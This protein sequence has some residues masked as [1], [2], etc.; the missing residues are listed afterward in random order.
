M[1]IDY[2]ETTNDLLTRIDIHNK[3]GGRDIDQW[4]LQ[5]LDLKPG[6]KILDVAC[7]GGKQCVSFH[8]YLKG[9]CEITGGDVNS[10]LLSQ[11]QLENGKL[12][13]PF[14]IMPLDFDKPLPFEDNTFDLVS[15]C[16][17]IYYASDIPFT[18]REMHRVLKPGGRLFTTGPMPEN[19]KVFYDIIR[20]ATSKTIPP[21]P[22]SSRY[23]SEIFAA[24]QNS[25]KQA[26]IHI[27]ENPLTFK[28]S[29]PFLAYTRASL[30][31]DRKLW[32]SLFANA[33][34]FEKIM[35]QIHRVA[36]ERVKRDGELVMTK[37]VGGFIGTKADA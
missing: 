20:E 16:F 6:M 31:E 1:K 2:Q 4:M 26:D 5:V 37:V 12:G 25:F 17:A 3:F 36:D 34:E 28:Q 14:R 18:I 10:E 30:S 27:F 8:S 29:A 15:C 21:M 24:I 32:S 13:N 19:K 11:A 35:Q 33:E 9:D 22:G 7:G 23:R